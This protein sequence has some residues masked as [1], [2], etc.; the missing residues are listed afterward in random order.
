MGADRRD[1]LTRL[2]DFCSMRNIAFISPY[3]LSSEAKNLLR[4]GVPNTTF[5]REISEKG[6]TA[7]C[8]QI[9]QV[10]D[11]EVYVHLFQ[12][13]G[14]KVLSVGR[15]KHRIPT[16]IDEEDKYFFM[17]FPDLNTPVLPDINTSP[18]FMRKLS[19]SMQGMDNSLLD[20]VLG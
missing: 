3:Q 18:K 7:D 20:E 1:Q 17:M 5:V 11:V 12:H 10:L 16:V 13:N 19:F 6:Y 15:G 9:D 8:K 2:H 14:K 4:N